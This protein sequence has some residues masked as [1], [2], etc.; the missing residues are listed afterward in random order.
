M[1]LEKSLVSRRMLLGAAGAS[2]AVAATGA[3]PKITQAATPMMGPSSPQYFRFKLGGFEIT[4]IA[5]GAVPVPTVSKIFGENQNS[6]DV[7]KHMAENNLPG[8]KM[9]IGFT[10]VIVNTGKEIVLFDSGNGAGRRP[11]AGKLLGA[12]EGAGFKA[13]QIDVVVITHFHGD[14]ISGLTEDG[15]PSFPNARYV[16]GEDEYNFWTDSKLSSGPM[17][18][19][20]KLVQ[21]KVVPFAEKMTFVKP[22]GEAAS[23]IRAVNAFGHT[24]GHM[25]WHVESDG[26]RF[27]LFADTTNHYV[28]SLQRPDW[29]VKFDMDKEKAIKTRKM[30]LD[31]VATDRIPSAGYHMP[32]PAV[33]YVEKHGEGYRWA[34]VSYQFNL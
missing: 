23:G 17:E 22:D 11:K 32:F 19:R 21:D 7:A 12:L 30:I 25:A 29:H 1:S 4:T 27:L 34:P 31:M 14:H 13:D 5:D 24:P 16:T 8:D 2:A 33:G 28:A 3:V 20:Y 15:K 9:E 6:E 18:K 26:K 10:P